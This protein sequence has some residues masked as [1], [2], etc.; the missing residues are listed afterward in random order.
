MARS[1]ARTREMHALLAMFEPDAV[2]TDNIWGYLWGKLAYGAMLFATALTN[3]SMTENFGD[4]RRFAVFQALG[5]EVIAVAKARGIRPVGFKEFDP[6]AFAPGAGEARLARRDR[7]ARRL[8]PPHRQDAFRHL[9]RP[10]GA[11]AQD[12]GR[13]RKSALSASLAARWAS[14]RPRSTD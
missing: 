5:R 10:C 14:P 9:A 4:P 6:E 8:H 3:D 1:V 12:R 7:L 2:L 13:T 11:Q